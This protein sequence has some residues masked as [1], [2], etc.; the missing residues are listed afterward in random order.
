MTGYELSNKQRKYFGLSL[1][2]EDWDKV[3][4]SDSVTVYY[5]GDSI[6]KVLHFGFGY[7]E[8]DTAIATK[9]RQWLLPKTTKG[10][11]QKLSVSRILKIKGSGIQFSGSFQGGGIHVY[12]NRRNLFF[13]KSY[14][15]DGDIRNYNDIEKWVTAFIN[16]TPA[17]Y[18]EWLNNQLSQKRKKVVSKQGDIIAFKIAER[19]YGFARVLLDVFAA[20][21]N[22]HEVTPI[23]QSFHPRSLFVA[24]YAFYASNLEIDIENLIHQATLPA[25]C[26][27]DI[28][29]Y[30]GEMPVVG[31]MPLSPKELQIPFPEKAATFISIPLSKKDIDT[32]ISKHG[33]LNH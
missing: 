23:L 7:V 31:H 27:F 1:V 6:V 13:I 3:R 18:F 4:L 28:A 2:S 25:I 21:Q 12:D 22:G 14:T 17:N 15:E 32:F 26:I 29:V 5:Q 8:Y 16:K 19:Q 20:R 11:E 33:H 24:P 9:D 10:K 30:R